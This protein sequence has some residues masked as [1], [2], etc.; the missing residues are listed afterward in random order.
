VALVGLSGSKEKGL[1]YL[2]EVAKANCESSVDAKVV[3]SL[4]LRREHRYDEALTV[5]R[6]LIPLY[7]RNVLFALEEGNL[8]RSAGKTQDAA[9][10]YRKVWQN[11]RAGRYPGLHY[12]VA[13]LSLGDLLRGQKDYAGAAAAYEQVSQ[14]SQ[15]DPEFL[16]RADLDAGE[17]YDLLQ[18]RDLALKKYQEVVA[19]DGNSALAGTARERIKD[20]YRAD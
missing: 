3:L 5:M 20:P 1:Q 10:V 16:Q 13:A 15:P 6:S 18:K 12:E 19:A 11:G 14:V 17:M 8:L 2:S 4:F 9:A 7:P